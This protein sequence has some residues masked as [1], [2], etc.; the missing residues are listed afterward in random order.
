MAWDWLDK[1][2]NWLQT[3][4]FCLAISALLVAFKP[5]QPYLV[6]MRYSVCIGSS[7]WFLIDFGRHLFPSAKEYGW[8]KGWGAFALPIVGNALGFLIG[9]AM[10]DVWNGWPG[11]S[12]ALAHQQE[13]RQSLLVSLIA[14]VVISYYFYSAGKSS[15]LTATV[16]EVR[17]QADEARLKLLE[18]Q[19]EPHMLFNTLANLRV[20]IGSDPAAAQ[21]MLD[22]IIS[23]MRA[24]L[25]AA[26]S[27][28]HSLQAEFDRLRDY[29]ELMQ[30]R[31]G[32]RLRY[33]LELPQ[34]LGALTVPTL[35]LQPLVENALK[36]GLEPQ[37]QG[38]SILVSAAEVDGGTLLRVRDNG[39]G[40]RATT[41][42]G[43][44]FG[45]HQVR[46]RLTTVYGPRARLTLEPGADGGAEAQIFLPGV[47]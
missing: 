30:I 5:D 24:T 1:L 25:G 45:L 33:E 40:L 4:A 21:T 11:S 14:G 31:M 15:H 6:G 44:R 17:Q 39:A 28:S 9:T 19:L 35:L 36:H 13:L 12:F 32:P 20:L 2:R 38:G 8:P 29:L 37:V 41:P 47:R 18:S 42:G 16:A 34:A 3:L 26:R 27:S 7:I 43:S 22:H 23:Y 46:E 10:G